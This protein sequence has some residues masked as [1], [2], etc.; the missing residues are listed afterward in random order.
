MRILR[1]TS[2][3]MCFGV[4]RAIDMALAR[5][6]TGRVSVLGQLVHNEAVIGRLQ[7]AGVEVVDS[8]TEINGNEV[9]ISAHGVSSSLK[10]NL[11]MNEVDFVDGTCPLVERLHRVVKR[12]VGHGFHPVII[13][14][15]RHVEVRGVTGDLEE[16][17]VVGAVD[18]VWKIKPH[19]RIGVVAQTT[20]PLERATRFLRIIRN[21]FPESEVRFVDTICRFTKERRRVAVELAKMSDAIVVVGGMNSNNTRELASLCRTHCNRVFHVMSK[22]ELSAEWFDDSDTV[23]ITSGTST[24]DED[25]DG[26]EQW[27]RYI[28]AGRHKT[29]QMAG[30]M[31][32]LSRSA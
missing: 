9:M 2:I 23:G 1:A 15:R 11:R 13:G 7:K 28:G 3:G 10:S 24:S 32:Y 29:M 21:R 16:F 8:L 20:C 26:V 4:R 17:D 12:L 22:N 25:I 27:L 18:D 19:K 14:K 31:S 5:A 30:S 6:A